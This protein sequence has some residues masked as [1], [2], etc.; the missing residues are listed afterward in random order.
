M[1]ILQKK[2]NR[3]LLENI[4]KLFKTKRQLSSKSK[5]MNRRHNALSNIIK[6]LKHHLYQY[7]LLI[8]LIRD[9]L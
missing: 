4:S 9:N 2:K 5:D 8:F 6:K 1:T 3:F 7:R